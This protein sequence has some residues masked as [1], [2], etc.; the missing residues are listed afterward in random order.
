MKVLQINT[1]CGNGSTGK[2]AVDLYRMLKQTGGDGTIVYGRRTAPED[3]PTI[4]ISG[5][6]DMAVHVLRNFFQGKSGF[7]SVKTTKALIAKIKE[8]KPDIIHLHNIHGFYINAE[9]LFSYLKV[10]AIPI[11]WTLHDCWAFTGHCAYFDYVGCSKWKE[12]CMQC[13]QHRSAYPYALFKDNSEWSYQKK[14]EIFTGVKSMTIVTPSHW[15]AGLVKESF[16]KEYPVEVI[17]NGIDLEIFRPRK[18][19]LRGQYG[20]SDKKVVLGVANIWETRKGLAYFEK[21]A[22]DLPETYKIVLVGLSAR[23]IKKL[24]EEIIGITRTNSMEELAEFYSVA[25]VYVNATLEENFP[26]TNLEAL[27]CGTPV[28]T[29]A[30][31]GSVE[32]V[33][34]SCGRI[35]DKGNLQALREAVVELC[36]KPLSDAVCREKGRSYGKTERFREYLELYAECQR[37]SI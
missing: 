12:N 31:G 32:S 33:D 18:S 35:V 26:T 15:L 17:H 2:I 21:L 4:K 8:Y 3:V 36:E 20:L 22:R 29:F 37:Q 9:L 30:T 19:N 5:Q 10:S 25:D 27:A 6:V 28:I 1:V 7:G 14:K 13:E 24:P 16:L 23:Q 34:E 11:V